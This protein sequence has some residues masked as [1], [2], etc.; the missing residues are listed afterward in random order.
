MRNNEAASLPGPEPLRPHAV[1][2]VEDEMLIRF[3]VA[4]YLRDRGFRVYEAHN[5][6]EA[7]EFLSFY[8][9]EID[10]VF[11]DIMTPGATDGFALTRWVRQYRPD[12]CV[13]LASGELSLDVL[14]EAE[15]ATSFFAKPY[16]LRAVLAHINE[17]I[18]ARD[19]DGGGTA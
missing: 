4:D 2:V 18:K 16:E 10:V 9:V 15:G 14:K 11:A 8:K 19:G 17:V 13:I 12:S 7:I 5:G 6:D 3:A 1:L